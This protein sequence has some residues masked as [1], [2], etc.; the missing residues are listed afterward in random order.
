MS[1]SRSISIRIKKGAD[2]RTALTCVQRLQ[3][4]QA[5]FFPR[6]DL[7]HYAVETVLGLDHGFFGLVADGWDLSD[8]GTPWPRGHLPGEANLAEMIVG[9]F[10]RER[11][12]GQFGSADELNEQ[13][14]SYAKEQAIPI[15]VRLSDADLDQV[16]RKRG[17]LFR[18][19]DAVPPGESLELAFDL[20]QKPAQRG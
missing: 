8:F 3:G 12:S 11:G 14:E 19:W 15:P 7:T 5:A 1:S 4:G 18:L 20:A 16:R 6:H 2:G 9:F 10:D 17:E 13:L